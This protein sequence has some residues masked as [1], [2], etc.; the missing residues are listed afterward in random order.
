MIRRVPLQSLEVAWRFFSKIIGTPTLKAKRCG[1][2]L[3]RVTV[4][5]NFVLIAIAWSSPVSTKSTNKIRALA[6]EQ[7]QQWP[8]VFHHWSFFVGSQHE[9]LSRSWD[10]L[11]P[12]NPSSAIFRNRHPHCFLGLGNQLRKPRIH[13]RSSYS[14]NKKYSREFSQHLD[15]LI[16]TIITKKNI[17]TIFTCPK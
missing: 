7:L 16:G 3:A 6:Q 5:R 14:D 11:I 4:L 15:C 8:R 9:A 12:R 17:F 13:G 1:G 10:R 2:I